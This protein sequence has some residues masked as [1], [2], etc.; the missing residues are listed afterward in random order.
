LFVH[1]KSI[2]DPTYNS[3][4][5]ASDNGSSPHHEVEAQSRF[6][7]RKEFEFDMTYRFVSGLP[8][9]TSM[10]AGHSVQAYST[11]DTRVGWHVIAAIDVSFV[12]QNLFQPQHSEFGGD[13]GALVGIRRSYYAKL[14]WKR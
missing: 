8:A 4:I 5:I 6:N 12:A 11:G 9:Q 1:N 13:D 7:L 2:A 10:P 14:T 3:L